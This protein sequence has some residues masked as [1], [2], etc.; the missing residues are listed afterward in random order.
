MPLRI[1]RF[2]LHAAALLLLA[3]AAHAQYPGVVGTAHR[4]EA[5][6]NEK[7]NYAVAQIS[8]GDAAMVGFDYESAFANFK[9]ALDTLP[10]GGSA[11]ADVRNQALE[12]F[13]DAGVKLARQRISEGRYADALLIVEK[14]LEEQYDPNY[15]PALSLRSQLLDPAKKDF[16]DRGTLT[17]GHVAKVE[18]IK[19]LLKEGEGFYA[20]GRYDLAL[21]RCELALNSD[22]Y[23]IA[24]RQLMVKINLARQQYAEAAYN[25]TRGE[26]LMQVAKAWEL[27]VRKFSEGPTS[28]INQPQISMRGTQIISDKLDAIRIPRID[29]TDSSIREAL[30]FIK[31]RAAELDDAETNNE[32][33]GV[34]IVLKLPPGSSESAYPITL[35]LT[36]VPLRTAI[37]YI[38]DAANMKIKVEPYAVVVVPQSENTD[39]LI[40]K[41]YK[42][43]PG[44]IQSIPGAGATS[45]AGQ[46]VASRS[47]AK[48]YL[49][50][51]GV[52]FPEG[53]SANFIS[54]TSRLIV[55]NTQSNL[56]LID[57]LVET[58]STTR[59]TQV[60]IEARFIE[61]TQNN[62][63]EFGFDWLLGQFALAG[64]SGIYGSGGTMGL[65]RSIPTQIDPNTG[66]V[67]PAIND[68]YPFNLN[69]YPIGTSGRP[70]DPATGG[71]VTAGNRNGSGAGYG[72][73]INLNALD[74]LL[75]GAA[76]AGAAPGVLSVAGVFT[77]PQF[78]VV[79]RALSQ[80]KGVDLVSAPKVTTQSGKTA[81]IEIIR[82]FRYVDQY[83]QPTTATSAGNILTPVAP[84]TPNSFATK[85]TGITLEV[86][87]TVAPDNYTIEMR[88]EP[89]I[90]EFDGFINYGSPIFSPVTV[91][92]P[93]VPGASISDNVLITDN[94]INK[95]VFSTKEV[96]TQVSLYDSQTVVLGGLMREDVQKVQDKVPIMG[97]IPFIGRL[98]RTDV[99]QHIK[100]NMIIFVTA[101]LLDPAGQPIILPEE[102]EEIISPSDLVGVSEG[103]I[104]TDALSVPA[105]Q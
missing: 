28:I 38:A 26:M 93:P 86:E 18:E 2:P 83:D 21:K 68:G 25:E 46:S 102:D 32:Q 104:A 56:D 57:A 72:T 40:T 76:G 8:K 35:S 58:A 16:I 7:K 39:V 27:P 77:N 62:L 103:A 99:D 91:F 63:N 98:F 14:V 10:P 75:L 1:P 31:N 52:A 5:L 71:P 87:P 70:G 22:K 20:T 105:T 85:N 60:E 29:F 82:E 42:V 47:M 33:K 36:D 96:S 74:A 54:S 48:D 24:A 101:G 19:K 49:E 17:P 9:S 53:A 89:R 13:C 23:N 12:G 6:R 69:G 30:D 34:N 66:A 44:F 90:I 88:L 78:Q 61:I 92:N 65:G 67:D 11:S 41:E 51:Q 64:G 45:T 15:D 55:K 94:Y 50:D 37:T 79:I 97:D 84:A 81:K 100:R 59:P 4:E 43:P 3:A 73:A 80:K 95:P